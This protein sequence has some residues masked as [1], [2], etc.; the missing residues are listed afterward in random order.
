MTTRQLPKQAAGHQPVPGSPWLPRAYVPRKQLWSHLDRGIRG[1]VT[2]VV[3]PTGAGKTLGVAGW[4][5]QSDAG[6]DAIWLNAESSFSVRH[7]TSVL[8]LAKRTESGTP[9]VVVVDDAHLLPPACIR[10]INERVDED[11]DGLRVVLLTRWD[12]ALSRLVAELLGQ[13]TVVRGD[14]LRL[15]AEETAQLVAE[16]ARTD[17]AAVC[18][19]IAARSQ[20]WC[21]AV[22][23]AAR[24]VAAAPS[25][26][27]FVQ[28]CRDAGPGI[29]DLVAGE[30]FA[31]L[32]SQE[33]HLLLCTAA[34][35]I[36]TARRRGAPDA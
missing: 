6:R 26:S 14:V 36:L 9:R 32:R 8:K 24:A 11:P 34:E 5:Q 28:R 23:L 22:V 1:A 3:A 17:S 16:H 25:R 4:L 29:A 31:S 19:A 10:L 20:G 15:D 18:E 33:R 7:L 30:V 21:A 35:P 12:L 2:M 13:L 27:D